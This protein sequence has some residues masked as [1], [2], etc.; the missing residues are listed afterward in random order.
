MYD[1]LF[2]LYGWIDAQE[3][4][5][6]GVRA[7][8][9]EGLADAVP[10]ET[11]ALIAVA[12]RPGELPEAVARHAADYDHLGLTDRRGG[13][14]PVSRSARRSGILEEMRAALTVVN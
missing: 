14:V 7:L 2:R 13:S 12:C 11:V 9:P 10:E 5:R 4:I 8:D 6:G 3:R 1:W